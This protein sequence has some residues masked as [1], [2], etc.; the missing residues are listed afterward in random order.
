MAQHFLL[1]AEARTLSLK[2]IYKGGEEKAYLT[3]KKLRWQQTNGEAV[4]PKC[5]CVDTYEIT[6]RR[7]FKCAACHAQF[8]VTSGTIFASR[9]LGFCDL[10]AA[11]CIFVN[12]SKG[13]S[14]LQLSRDID[15]QYK[16]AWVMA[17][18]LREALAAETASEVVEGEVEIDGAYFGGHVRPENMKED[19]K[20][21]RLKANQSDRRRVVIALRQ[22]DGR[23]LT[24]VRREEAEGVAIA[25]ARVAA[26]SM[27][28]ADEAAH[29]DAL[30][31]HYET[32]RI[33]HS[34]MYSDLNG[35]HTNM[36]ESFFSR[37]R[38]MV[39][40]Q[41]HH[42]SHKYLYQYANHAA[43]MEDH[44]RNSNGANAFSLL[45]A[46]LAHPVSRTWKGYWQR[47]SFA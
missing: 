38:R 36:V 8:S 4:C 9:K 20:D 23:T 46:S 2:E 11:I 14:A 40:G 21:R 41:H 12:A 45:G 6:T 17:H 27:L 34:Q 7:K 13:L 29:W 18:K 47:S 16:T 31:M 5:G 42:V 24:F 37:L 15:V 30:E 25:K 10:L 44:R 39:Q 35:K 33:N 26:N 32:G 43:W 3:F 28:F 22:R 19:R 1:S